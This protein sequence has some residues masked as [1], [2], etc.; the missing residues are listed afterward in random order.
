[1][2]LFDQDIYPK[3]FLNDVYTRLDKLQDFLIY[4]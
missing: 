2:L 3:K 1:M 4:N